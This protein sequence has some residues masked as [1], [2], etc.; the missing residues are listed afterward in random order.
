V[1]R[2]VRG[3]ENERETERERD[4]EAE[5]DRE[6]E[7]ESHVDKV[8]DGIPVQVRQSGKSGGMG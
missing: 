3:T 4:T 5:T 8:D 6:A 1:T 2:T 7:Q